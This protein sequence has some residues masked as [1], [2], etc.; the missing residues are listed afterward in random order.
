MSNR[1]PHDERECLICGLLLSS[2]TCCPREP[3]A[4]ELDL[5]R[6]ARMTRAELEHEQEVPL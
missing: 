4:D 2:C 3:S 5:G 1:D 6:H